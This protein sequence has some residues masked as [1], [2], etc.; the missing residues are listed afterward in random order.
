MMLAP[1]RAWIN[2]ITSMIFCG[3]RGAAAARCGGRQFA[4]FAFDQAALAA[5]YAVGAGLASL[6]T[7][8]PSVPSTTA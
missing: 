5:I 4:S 6:R 8:P 2:A 3:G 7:R 1:N